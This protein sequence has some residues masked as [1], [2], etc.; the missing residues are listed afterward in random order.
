MEKVQK[1]KA[2]KAKEAQPRQQ[3]RVQAEK[4]AAETEHAKAVLRGLRLLRHKELRQKPGS[5]LQRLRRPAL[6]RIWYVMSHQTFQYAP[7]IAATLSG[8]LLSM[9][10]HAFLSTNNLCKNKLVELLKV[11]QTAAR[12][13][14]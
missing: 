1:A 10:T 11:Q 12:P 6:H 9:H 5:R 4:A 7:V 2:V 3:A 13:H 14:M 8:S